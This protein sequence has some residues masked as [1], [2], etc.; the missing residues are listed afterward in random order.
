MVIEVDLEVGGKQPD[1][2]KISQKPCKASGSPGRYPARQNS[3]QGS[4]VVRE[5]D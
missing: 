3:Q 5:L 2:M 4:L 1:L